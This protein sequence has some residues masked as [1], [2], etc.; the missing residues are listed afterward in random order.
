LAIFTAIRRASSLLRF[1]FKLCD[2]ARKP[3]LLVGKTAV[4]LSET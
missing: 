2:V 1:D 3:L 4:A